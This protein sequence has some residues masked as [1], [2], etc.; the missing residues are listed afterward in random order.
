MVKSRKTQ[1][2][3]ATSRNKDVRAGAPAPGRSKRKV[4]IITQE[5]DPHADLMALRLEKRGV[6]A[7]RFHP[8]SVGRSDSLTLEFDSQGQRRWRLE[9]AYGV[10]Q[11]G[12][13]G[14]VWY[15]RPLFALDPGL[16]EEEALFSQAETRHAV[17][18]LFRL[19]EAFWVNPPDAIRVAESK[20]LQLG[21]A[22][23]LGFRVPHTLLTNDPGKFK[24]FYE[25]CRGG[26]IF[27][28]MTQGA[29]GSS[30]GKGVYTSLVDRRH[31]ENLATI[32][33]APC[34]FQEHIPKALD[35]RVTVIGDQIFPV[36]IHSQ[37]QE[38]AKIDWRQGKTARLKHEMHQLPPEIAAQCF[39]LLKSL[40]LV[41]GAI[42]L[43]LTPQGEYVFLE[44]NPSGQF[45]WIEAF[46]KVPLVETLADLLVSHT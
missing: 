7:V 17:L 20:P 42:D 32:R 18:G 37:G 46:I 19:T 27:K 13:V 1:V 22:Q 28:V 14:S 43:V 31:L 16:S 21:L 8:Q 35:L 36:A 12:E 23:R 6:K 4:L 5:I 9:G 45:A 38:D 15:R 30:A 10:L 11:D 33:Q 25:Q 39:E 26:V 44:I 24:E 2:E 34:L 3:D 41:Y 40:Q 29:L